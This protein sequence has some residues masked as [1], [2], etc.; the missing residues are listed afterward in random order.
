MAEKSHREQAVDRITT[1][2]YGIVRD[3]EGNIKSPPPG[4]ERDRLLKVSEAWRDYR[5]TGDEKKL[6]D[7][8]IFPESESTSKTPKKRGQGQRVQPTRISR[9]ARSRPPRSR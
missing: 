4:P 7:L 3:V 2:F 9:R 1:P 8:E 5:K 6:V